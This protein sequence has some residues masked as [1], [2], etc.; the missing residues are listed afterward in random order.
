MWLINSFSEPFCFSFIKLFCILPEKGCPYGIQCGL[1]GHRERGTALDLWKSRESMSVGF[2]ILVN[3]ILLSS[4][5]N[6]PFYHM[7]NLE[8]FQT[9][10]DL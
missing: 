1:H 10:E 9:A 2:C 7:R 5:T 3:A 8:D 6:A 4:N